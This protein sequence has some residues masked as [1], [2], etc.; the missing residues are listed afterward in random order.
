PSSL[1]KTQ[2]IVR[3]DD[4]V[5]KATIA[6]PDETGRYS[7]RIDELAN[8]VA[9]FSNLLRQGVISGPGIIKSGDH[10]NRARVRRLL[11]QRPHQWE[12]E[13]NCQSAHKYWVWFHVAY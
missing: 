2:A 12:H 10:F 7:V 9:S 5:A 4:R 11:T 8:D 13:Q 6:E 1:G 3:V